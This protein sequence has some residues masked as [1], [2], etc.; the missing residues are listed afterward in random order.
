MMKNL[1]KFLNKFLGPM[2]NWM[3]GNAFFS[4]LAASFMRTLPITL[5]VSVLMIIGGFPVL[6][7]QT[8]LAT[9]QL[10]VEFNA[11]IGASMNALSLFVTFNF[12]YLYAKRFKQNGLT[13]A[14][15]AITSFLMLMPQVVQV[16]ALKETL[17]KFPGTATV[18]AINSVEA[19]QTTYTGGS[20]LFVGI[21]VAYLSTKLFIKL[22]EKHFVV[23]LPD[24]VPP[25]VSEALSPAFISIFIFI[26]FFLI[27]LSFHFT[28]FG[29]IFAFMTNLV[30]QPL[31]AVT[32]NPWGIIVIATVTNLFWFFGI[33]PSMVLGA[34][35]PI[36]YAIFN[37]NINAYAHGLAIPYLMTAVVY[38]ATGNGFGGQ[39]GTY[40]LVFS[41]LG[42]KSKR[43]QQLVKL[44]LI[45]AIFNI[46]EPLIFGMPIILNPLFFIPM[47]LSAA[48]MGLSAWGMATILHVTTYFAT[49]QLPWT[50]PGFLQM[51]IYGGWKW[52]VIMVVILLLN[53]A[54]W[55]PFFGIADRRALLEESGVKES[56]ANVT[57]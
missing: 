6:S 12:A 35:S 1:E 47:I 30:Q 11:V 54:L 38:V 27:R 13:S 24:S 41:M 2:A 39:G 42:V 16:P 57:K 34:A 26:V 51:F 3:N 15:I 43:Y 45:P 55:Y 5:G 21:L 40:G 56:E 46:N 18:T 10:N 25:M 8:F 19:F 7:W 23:K 44:E 20:G 32:G 49:A 37:E 52:L 17:T 9:S 33:H 4:T 31:Q 22:N 53:F 14:L 29:N 50:M 36:L 48:V 28:P